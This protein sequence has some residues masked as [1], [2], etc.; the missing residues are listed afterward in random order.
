MIDAKK[1][2][3]FLKNNKISFFCGVPDSILKEFSNEIIK[4]KGIKHIISPNEGLA[5]S[6]AAGYNLS[7]NK[8]PC[9]YLQNSGLGNTIN[10]ISSIAHKKVYSI[11]LLLLIGWRGAPKIKDEPQ[12]KVKGTITKKLLRLL[13][14]K[15]SEITNDLNKTKNLIN[16]AKKNNKPVAILVK[17]NQFIKK[18]TNGKK[19]DGILRSDFISTLLD[20]IKKKTKII[21]T[22]GFTSREL[23]Q[24]RN[25]KKNNF[26]KDFYMVGGMGH[27]S[28]LALGVSV[29]NKKEVVCLDGDGALLMHLGSMNL[30]GHLSKKNFKHIVFNN[31]CHESVGGQSTYSENINFELLSKSL[32]YK[33]YFKIDKYSQSTNTIKKFLKKDGPSILEV[34]TKIGTLNNLTRP[35]KLI[36]LKNDFKNF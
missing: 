4:T 3:K 1:F 29:S 31:Y 32:G 14:I 33:Y 23:F 36:K 17:K 27:A 9:V 13:D 12:H 6:L 18:K 28:S 25:L 24:L 2:I 21:S 16:Y 35:K 34:K 8:L 19:T 15:Y 10:P 20:L 7:T 11:P 22:T 26:S 5:V 30:I